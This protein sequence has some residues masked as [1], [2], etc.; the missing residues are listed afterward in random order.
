MAAARIFLAPEQYDAKYFAALTSRV[1]RI[2]KLVASDITAAQAVLRDWSVDTWKQ[3]S[4][5]GH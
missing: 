2:D 1:G 5:V 4:K 3:I